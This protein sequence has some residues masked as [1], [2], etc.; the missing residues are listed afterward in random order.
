MHFCKMS[1]DTSHTEN[2]EEDFDDLGFDGHNGDL[3]LRLSCK[4]ENDSEQ[5]PFSHYT[6]S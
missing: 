1:F 2:H 6:F 4:Q 3:A 5:V